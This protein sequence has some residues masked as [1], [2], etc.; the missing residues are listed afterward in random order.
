MRARNKQRDLAS[1]GIAIDDEMRKTEKFKAD[2][3]RDGYTAN[4]HPELFDHG[5]IFGAPQEVLLMEGKHF[6]EY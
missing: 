6:E 3:I 1:K 4:A 5:S 2:E